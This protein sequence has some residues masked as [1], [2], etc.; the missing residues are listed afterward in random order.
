L[1]QGFQIT[2]L[3]RQR[4]R[5]SWIWCYGSPVLDTDSDLCWVCNSCNKEG[6]TKR[7]WFSAKS[8][9]NPIKH[10][11]REHGIG[12]NGPVTVTPQAPLPSYC[13]MELFRS[14]FLEWK[15]LDQNFRKL[16]TSRLRAPDARK[17]ARTLPI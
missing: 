7:H 14:L 12:R 16:A 10:L 15:V 1:P 6:N 4:G 5:K 9:S 3:Q 17:S 2:W 8:T 11:G 13:N